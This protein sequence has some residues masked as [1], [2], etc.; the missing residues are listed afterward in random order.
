M[1]FGLTPR[2]QEVYDCL[3]LHHDQTGTMPTVAELAAR[4]GGSKGGMHAVLTKL[5]EKGWIR[6]L[7]ARERGIALI[8]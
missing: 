2:Q 4:A 5:E 3:V 1:K 8:D 6:K 7:V